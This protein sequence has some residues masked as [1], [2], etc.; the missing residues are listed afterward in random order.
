MK[1]LKNQDGVSL[2]EL[3][4]AAAVLSVLALAFSGYMRNVTT[5]Q[6][7]AQENMDMLVLNNQMS[8]AANDPQ[9]VLQSGNLIHSS[10]TTTTTTTTPNTVDPWDLPPAEHNY[11]SASY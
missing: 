4:I 10:T 7:Y 3:M 11:P 2:V 5:Q 8:A 1:R 6:K 9:S